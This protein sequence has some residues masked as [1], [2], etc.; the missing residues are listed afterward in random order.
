ML[1]SAL[2]PITLPMLTTRPATRSPLTLRK[3]LYR[4]LNPSL[5]CFL[6][7]CI[8]NPADELV[9]GQDGDVEP[10]GTGRFI[11]GEGSGQVVGERVDCAAW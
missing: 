5:T 10:G 2:F 11:L 1:S 6:L 3:L 7:L 4:T 9:P 8:A